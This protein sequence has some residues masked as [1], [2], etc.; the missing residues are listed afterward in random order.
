MTRSVK[1]MLGQMSAHVDHMRR[2]CNGERDDKMHV[3]DE[4]SDEMLSTLDAIVDVRGVQV[5]GLGDNN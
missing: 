2:V 3:L 1:V 5:T 4:I